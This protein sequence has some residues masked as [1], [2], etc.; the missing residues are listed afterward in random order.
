MSCSGAS[1]IVAPFGERSAPARNVQPTRWVS[2][3]ACCRRRAM[4]NNDAESPSQTMLAPPVSTYSPDP[5][6]MERGLGSRIR[7]SIDAMASVS[8]SLLDVGCLSDGW[9]LECPVCDPWASS[10][11]VNLPQYRLSLSDD[12][13]MS[14]DQRFTATN[15]DSDAP[16]HPRLVACYEVVKGQE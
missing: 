11:L 5:L 8:I 4:G 1:V 12:C 3:S 9:F 13:P 10:P 16:T 7:S 15:L 14:R 2:R 6:V